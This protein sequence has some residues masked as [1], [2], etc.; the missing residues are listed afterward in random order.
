MLPFVWSFWVGNSV[1]GDG[2]VAEL[3]FRVRGVRC[4]GF[5]FRM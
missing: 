1:G 3:A 2:F 5:R 4:R